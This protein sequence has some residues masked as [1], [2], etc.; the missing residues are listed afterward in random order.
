MDFMRKFLK[1][2]LEHFL[3]EFVGNLS[4]IFEKKIFWTIPL[5]FS[6]YF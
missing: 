4:G 2:I 3:E 5:R 6:G 1:L